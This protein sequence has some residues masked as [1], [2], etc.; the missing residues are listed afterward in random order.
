M[1]STLFKRLIAIAVI[2]SIIACGFLGFSIILMRD[3][4]IL[5]STD[6][7]PAM[8][9]GIAAVSLLTALSIFVAVTVSKAFKSFQE[10]IAYLRNKIFELEKKA[11][12][13]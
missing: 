9:M 6:H 4:S 10:E 5:L 2:I 8:V 11:D 7:Y 12:K 1:D 13:K 3:N